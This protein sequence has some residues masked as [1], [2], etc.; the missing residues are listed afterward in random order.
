M[1]DLGF[2]RKELGNYPEAEPTPKEDWDE[3][4][5]YPELYLDGKQAV[6]M[7]AKDLKIGETFE[8]PVKFEVKSLTKTEADGKI[9]YSM[10]LCLV[11]MGDVE[12]ED[13]DSEDME[14]DDTGETDSGDQVL[15]SI[16]QQTD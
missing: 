9:S 6:A 13:E 2:K 10:R 5:V 4:M 16:M 14:D 7:G 3:Q 15:T 12:S 1:T 8:A 11:G